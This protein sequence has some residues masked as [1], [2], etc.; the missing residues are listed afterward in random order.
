MNF[1]FGSR[2]V[3]TE[4][5]QS[6]RPAFALP[7]GWPLAGSRG[8][9]LTDVAFSVLNVSAGPALGSLPGAGDGA[10]FFIRR[11]ALAEAA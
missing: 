2:L 10:T 1:F 3:A 6:F 9:G 5:G 4:W 8:G 11:P 7:F